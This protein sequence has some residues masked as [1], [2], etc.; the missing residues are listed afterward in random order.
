MVN[1]ILLDL[2]GTL[3]DSKLGITTCIRY[4]LEQLGHPLAHHIDLDWTIGPPIKAS[5]FK[6]LNT[7]D[8]VLVDRAVALYRE[9]FSV[10]GLFE[11][12]VY[13]QVASTLETLS[14]R[15]YTI[16]LATA[17]AQV[18]A[19]RILEHFDLLKYF[20]FPYGSELTGERSDKSELIAYILEQENL[21]PAQCLMVG[22]RQYDILGARHNQIQAIAVSYGYGTAEELQG[23]QPYAIID[24]FSQLLEY[25]PSLK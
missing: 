21:T 2:D 16:Y 10:T 6:I 7:Q 23:T 18:Y 25:C 19:I 12:D 22:D 11:N 9:R 15:G 17:K 14:E 13:P 24:Q 5:F 4:A 1:T 20:K 8:E 3:T